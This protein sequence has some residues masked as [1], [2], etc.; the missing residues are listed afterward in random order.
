MSVSGFIDRVQTLHA[1]YVRLQKGI[2]DFL[3]ANITKTGRSKLGS[4]VA[5][6]RHIADSFEIPL[7]SQDG[8]GEEVKPLPKPIVNNLPPGVAQ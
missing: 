2:E 5:T 6:I 4:I 3:L 7:K 1:N 8:K